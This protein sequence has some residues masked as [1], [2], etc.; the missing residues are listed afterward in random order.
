MPFA[1]EAESWIPVTEQDKTA[2][3][4]QLDR[5]VGNPYFHHSKRYPSFLKFIVVETL[6]GR[7]EN[8]K[9]RTLGI[10]VFGREPDYD[11]TNDP[12]VRVTAAEIRKRIAQYYQEPGHEGEIRLS[13]P[14]GSYIPHFTKP[15]SD[16]VSTAEPTPEPEPEELPKPAV[17][18]AEPNLV[19]ATGSFVPRKLLVV[20]VVA[21]LLI[22]SAALWQIFRSSP[23][24]DFWRPF[25]TSDYPVLFCIADQSHFSTI[26]LRDAADP[27]R[28]SVLEDRMITVIID[29]VSPLVDIAG[30]LQ[31]HRKSYQVKGEAATTLTDLRQGPTV[32]IGAFD[33]SWTLRVTGPLRF[34]FANNAEMSKFWIEDRQDPS[35][36]NW[37]LDR[38]VQQKTGTYKDYAIVARFTD[39]D[40]DRPVVAAAGLARGG[41]VA[42]GEFLVSPQH[43]HDLALQAPKGWQHKN[44]E[45]VLETQIIDGRSGP[46][47][48]AAVHVW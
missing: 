25:V 43:M 6:A 30:M 23:I 22:V 18:T 28:Q 11:T 46:P 8:L 40:T 2:I 33:N 27:Q 24:D 32:L 21:A 38:T 41:T 39:P 15:A 5:L 34:H 14:S 16:T 17:V 47:R 7:A 3:L 13:L 44:I 1:Q 45:V 10:E 12:I 29:D 20:T 42:A 4:E 48:V 37:L 36:K 26:T 9:E 19:P 35:R 31:V